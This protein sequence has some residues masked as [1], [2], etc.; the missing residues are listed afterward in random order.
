MFVLDCFVLDMAYQ[1]HHPYILHMH[2]FSDL[3]SPLLIANTVGL[4]QWILYQ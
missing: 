3:I 1:S 2:A 4:D